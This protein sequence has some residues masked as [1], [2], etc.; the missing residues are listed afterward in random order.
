MNITSWLGVSLVTVATGCGGTVMES[1]KSLDTETR[2]SVEQALARCDGS[3]T[4]MSWHFRGPGASPAALP[5]LIE[6]K[7]VRCPD[8]SAQFKESYAVQV[9]AEAVC[10]LEPDAKGTLTAHVAPSCVSWNAAPAPF[11]GVQFD[12]GVITN[13]DFSEDGKLFHTCANPYCAV[14]TRID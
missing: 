6:G 8:H 2:A 7:W 12:L 11:Q 14:Y 10:P 4:D 13:A 9:S 5:A 3:V 1:T